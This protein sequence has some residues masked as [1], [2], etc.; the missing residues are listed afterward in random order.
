LERHAEIH[1][2]AKA[3]IRLRQG[4]TRVASEMSMTLAEFLDRSAVTWDGVKV[5]QPDWSDCSHT[6][7]FTVTGVGG[8]RYYHFILNAYSEPLEFE[9]PAPNGSSCGWLRLVDTYLEPP[10]DITDYEAAV[11]VLG[12]TYTMGPRSVAMF[13]APQ[14]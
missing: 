9:L 10:H 3:M 13:V 1:R 6:L 8:K 5:G 4:Q 12:G 14:G 11:E 7:S 2:F